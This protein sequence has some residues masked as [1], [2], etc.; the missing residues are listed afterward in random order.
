MNLQQIRLHPIK[1]LDGAAVHSVCITPHHSLADDRS[2]VLVD[3]L[4]RVLRAKQHPHLHR[5]R[6]SYDLAKRQAV[7]SMQDAPCSASFEMDHDLGP[8]TR[9]LCE[10]LGMVVRVC[11]VAHDPLPDDPNLMGPTV[12]STGSLRLAA[13]HLSL[14]A[15]ELVR[16]FR[17]NLVIEAEPFWED[18]LIAPEGRGVPFTIGAITLVGAAPCSRCPVPARDPLTGILDETFTERFMTWRR[19]T[20]PA[21]GRRDRVKHDNYFTTRTW[22]APGQAGQVLATGDPVRLHEGLWVQPPRRFSKFDEHAASALNGANATDG[23]I[24]HG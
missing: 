20:W 14:S 17:V 21:W 15:D 12:V 5:V 19:Q 13:E 16:R 7:L 23:A 10:R 24:Q 3:E 6:A 9:W 22:I 11:R 2:I 18:R 4:G 1:S 8:M